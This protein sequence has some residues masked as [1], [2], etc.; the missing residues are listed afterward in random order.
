MAT[1]AAKEDAAPTKRPRKA[2]SASARDAV[3]AATATPARAARRPK[4][5]PAPATLIFF[6]RHGTTPT[7]GQVLPGRAPGLHLADSGKAEAE[8][9]A[10]RLAALTIPAT[11]AIPANGTATDSK[12]TDGTP[13]NSKVANGK[14]AHGTE[15]AHAT[16][17]VAAVYASP[18]ERARETAA[19]IG[20]RLGRKVAIEKGLIEMDF[21][22]WTGAELKALRKLPEWNA[23]QR[24]P[25]GFQFP[26]G[27]AFSA[28][29]AR[30]AATVAMLCLRHPGEAIV[31]V[32]HADVIKAAVSDA[33]GTHLD[34][35]QRIVVSTCSVTAISYSPTG[36]VVLAVNSTGGLGAL[37]PS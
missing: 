15:A 12:A 20:K 25:S 30:I 8:A 28:M 4:P 3:T 37:R 7:T 27:E 13:A 34:L 29:R 2:I 11:P 35:F 24:Y 17:S 1:P 18:L 23:V 16:L 22:E 31:A 33:L 6:V 5:T 32:S 10:E 19:P 26:G 36:P 14:A 9:V 21:G